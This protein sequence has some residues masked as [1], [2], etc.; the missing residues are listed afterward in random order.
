[1]KRNGFLVIAALLALSIAACDGFSTGGSSSEDTQL[2][3]DVVYSQDGASLTL[4]LDGSVPVSS[5][6]RALTTDL[7]RSGH[8]YFE[9][10]FYN[11]DGTNTQVARA[12]WEIGES[13]GIRNVPRGVPGTGINYNAAGAA[14]IGTGSYA[15]LFVGRKSDKTLLAIGQLTNVDNA[16]TPT[17][18]VTTTSTRVTFEVTAL[19]AGLRLPSTTT[20]AA[21]PTDTFLT[22]AE[23]DVDD[24]TDVSAAN[25][26]LQTATV[27]SY[28]FPAYGLPLA[29]GANAELPI[30]SNYLLNTTA[31]NTTYLVGVRVINDAA[32]A[33]IHE[34]V[35]RIPPRFPIGGGQ[36]G[37]I[38]GPYAQETKASIVA[39]DPDEDGDEMV[40]YDEAQIEDGMALPNPIIIK[41]ITPNYDASTKVGGVCSLSFAI[42]VYAITT[43]VPAG[44]PEPITWYVRPGFGTN[45]YDLDDGSSGLGSSILLAVGAVELNFLEIITVLP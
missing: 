28:S 11:N 13:A 31:I 1:M 16:G 30:L 19:Q 17:T 24:G 6:Q 14:A 2:F 23:D 42:P 21:A 41:I 18:T 40:H 7:A 37:Y 20:P 39:V 27:G 44:G 4:Y 3:T 15:I 45:V 26:I 29:T 10:V 32:T 8:D 34:A 36:Y 9:V 38:P 12:A 35:I 25:T 43:A 22:A 33:T 5:G